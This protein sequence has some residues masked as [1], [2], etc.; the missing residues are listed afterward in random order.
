[1]LARCLIASLL[2]LLL[3][4]T[5]RA[6][7]ETAAALR[8]FFEALNGAEPVVA[9]Q[10]LYEAALL[11]ALYQSRDNQPLWTDG[12]PLATQAAA[13]VDAIE[14]S[15]AHGLNGAH[16]HLAALRKRIQDGTGGLAFEL[17]ASDAYLRQVRHRSAG[18]VSPRDLDRDWHLAAPEVD[19]RRAL[20]QAAAAGTPIG[21]RLDALWPHSAEYQRLVEQRAQILSLGEVRTVAVPAGGLLRP[22]QENP[23]V[24]ALK[25]RLL[26]PGEHSALFDPELREAVVAFQRAAGL[27]PDGIV[28]DATLEVLNASRFSW[29]DRIDANLERWR[30]LP[31]DS[32]DTYVR[33]NIAAFTL[34]VIR[35]NEDALRMDVIV[36]R[37]Y[38]R[39]P[40]FTAPIKYLVVNPYWNV[41]YRLAVQDK[42]PTLK[43][44]PSELATQGFEVRAPGAERFAAL[45]TVDWSSVDRHDFH[46]ALRQRPG[47]LNALGQVKLMLPNPFDVYLHDTPSR[48][49]FNRQERSFSSGCIRLSRPLELASW[50]LRN[51]GQGAAAERLDKV[52]AGGE[53]TTMYLHEPLPTYLVYFTAFTDD[54]A[55]VVF[56]RD[57]YQRDAPIVAALR[58][59]AEG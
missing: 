36:G 29:I 16:Y 23:R 42:L 18:V 12:G 39:T 31:A 52:V 14:Q 55:D 51:D 11:G 9:D 50:V 15:R 54:T 34:R 47:P 57:L 37:P 1:M 28:G 7:P 56:R 30:W 40:V 25:D 27:E 58:A 45:D 8:G 44:D 32:P 59:G 46:Y 38:R 26:G 2:T 33:V 49:L 13:L 24:M 17:L 22:G 21:P 41:P 35:G 43:R 5:A 53:T 19:P 20:E 10:P 48:E 6:E 4:D 3:C